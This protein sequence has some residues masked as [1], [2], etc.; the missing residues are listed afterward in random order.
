MSRAV[1]NAP[2]PS[3]IPPLQNGDHLT[4]AEFERRFD[5]TP[6]LKKAELIEGVVYMPPPVSVDHG[7]PHGILAALLVIYSAAT[8]GTDCG[9]DA[10]VRLNQKNMPQ[11]DAYLM[12]LSGWGGQSRISEDRYIEGAPELVGEVAVSSASYDLHDKLEAYRRNHVREYIVIR[13]LDSAIDYL[14]LRGETYDRLLP[15]QQGIWRSECFPGLWID[16]KSLLAGDTPAA[17]D[18][19]NRGIAS[20]EHAEFVKRLAAKH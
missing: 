1:P 17:L 13:T 19:L 15:D 2:R 3:I 9:S 5:A 14:I 12:I 7:K 16:G 4:L 18:V 6:N 20:P 8:P 11:P 10:S